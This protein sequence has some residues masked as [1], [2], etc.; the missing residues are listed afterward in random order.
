L[1]LKPATRGQGCP[2]SNRESA[3]GPRPF[4]EN[5]LVP[6]SEEIVVAAGAG[7]EANERDSKYGSTRTEAEVTI[8]PPATGAGSGGQNRSLKGFGLFLLV[9]CAAFWR[10]L[11][12]LARYAARSELYS[13]ILILPVISLYLAALKRK[14]LPRDVAGNATAACIPAFV[15]LLV[16]LSYAVLRA[17]GWKPGDNDYLS[18]TVF[19]WFFFLTGGF[20]FFFGSNTLRALAFPLGFLVFM[21]PFP[22]TFTNWLEAFLQHGSADAAS[23]L[24]SL[25]G[26]TVFRS[27]QVFQLPGIVLEVAKECSGIHSSLVLFLTSL[28]AGHLCLRSPW[29]RAALALAVLPL[30]I[31]RNGVRIFTI[32]ML[33]VHV[34]PGMIQSPIHTRGG[35][36]FFVLSLLPFFVLLFLLRRSERPGKKTKPAGGE[37][38]VRT[39]GGSVQK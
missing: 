6:D 14:A 21:A 1:Y 12:D 29:K 8:P 3:Q 35:P 28:L 37:L 10:P 32:A 33:C 5:L 2:R 36:V 13:H 27:G 25:T 11:F 34:D 23:A 26:A 30:G 31:A 22:S 9:L 20:L 4:G 7:A 16:L 24:F 17:Q 15:G 39:V 19:S 38:P 18:I